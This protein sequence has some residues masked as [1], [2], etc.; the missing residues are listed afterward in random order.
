MNTTSFHKIAAIGLLL[1]TSLVSF[2]SDR[3]FY[4]GIGV[5]YSSANGE[6]QGSLYSPEMIRIPIMPPTF[7]NNRINS[8][9]IGHLDKRFGLHLLEGYRFNALLAAEVEA[10]FYGQSSDLLAAYALYTPKRI[11]SGAFHLKAGLSYSDHVYL[12]GGGFVIEWL[13]KPQDTIALSG[14]YQ[15]TVTYKNNSSDCGFSEN[16]GVVICSQNMSDKKRRLDV[17]N[18]ALTYQHYFSPRQFDFNE[19]DS[20]INHYFSFGLDQSA[21]TY[22]IHYDESQSNL[23]KWSY[24]AVNLN[25]TQGFGF[26]PYYSLEASLH[27]LSARGDELRKK[28]FMMAS[29]DHRLMTPR[30]ADGLF[31]AYAKLGSFYSNDRRGG[32]SYGLGFDFFDGP[33]SLSIGWQRMD[34]RNATVEPAP[35]FYHDLFGVKATYSLN[36]QALYQLDVPLPSDEKSSLY[37]DFSTASHSGEITE[38]SQFAVRDYALSG[39]EGLFSLGYR[40]PVHKYF[41]VGA[42]ASLGTSSAVDYQTKRPTAASVFSFYGSIARDLAYYASIVPGYYIAPHAALFARLGVARSSWSLDLPTGVVSGNHSHQNGGITAST[43]NLDLNGVLVGV[44]EH[45]KLSSHLSLLLHYDHTIYRGQLL[46]A[47]PITE[48]AEQDRVDYYDTKD[49]H[50]KPKEDRFGL[51]VEYQVQA[52]SQSTKPECFLRDG[53]YFGL[54]AERDFHYVKRQVGFPEGNDVRDADF[55][56]NHFYLDGTAARL[57]IGYE[58]VLPENLVVAL[59]LYG[60]VGNSEHVIDKLYRKESWRY[61]TN[62]SIGGDILLG[63]EYSPGIMPYIHAGLVTTE[64]ERSGLEE[65]TDEIEY[66]FRKNVEGFHYGIGSDVALTQHFGLRFDLSASE[67]EGLGDGDAKLKGSRNFIYMKNSDVNYAIGFRYLI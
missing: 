39:Y 44:G 36:P 25:L 28:H 64:F 7:A 54:M 27:Y 65:P 41:F 23:Y 40:V 35:H 38:S 16:D 58:W 15:P 3:G 30:F 21:T 61:A 11:D 2:A 45:I 67:Y 29:V 42:E 18:I 31:D 50:F 33:R 4:S 24:D 47:M 48:I 59:E 8:Q 62:H 13:S 26:S 19:D 17:Y 52:Y 53:V 46:K 51:G 55:H 57:S 63:Y 56:E 20:R 12:P 22:P 34:Y 6:T 49:F 66:N 37:F 5:Q 14:I 32:L 43:Q 10:F 9:G 60:R 1:T